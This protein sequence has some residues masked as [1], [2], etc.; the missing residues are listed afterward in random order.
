MT[1]K[2]R[3]QTISLCLTLAGAVALPACGKKDE[4]AEKADDEEEK[5]D[6]KKKKE[7]DDKEEKSAAKFE[8]GDKVEANWKGTWYK[9][10]VLAVK[11]GKYEIHYEG[12][13]DTWNQEVEEDKLRKPEGIEY[14][15]K[16]DDEVEVQW[17]EKWYDATILEVEGKDKFKV[18][19]DGWDDQWDES[20]D[21]N[22]IRPKA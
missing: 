8:K 5:A 20:V 3:I 16:K 12:W 18:H 21:G 19:Y 1:M 22:R 2:R 17:K 9:A 4:K 10:E 6:D 15:Y 14:S 7:D 13:S 11:D